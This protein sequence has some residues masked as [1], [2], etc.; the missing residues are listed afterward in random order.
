MPTTPDVEILKG[1]LHPHYIRTLGPA[2]QQG[3]VSS[4]SH[5]RILEGE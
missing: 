3:L 4:I 2:G 5:C 1:V